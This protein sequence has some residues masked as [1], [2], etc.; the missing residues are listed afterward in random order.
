MNNFLNKKR[1]TVAQRLMAL[2]LIVAL[3]LSTFAPV[4]A[5][6]GNFGNASAFEQMISGMY[7]GAQG[8][9]T[10]S[11]GDFAID[12]AITVAVEVADMWYYTH[13]YS[14]YGKSLISF[15]I[16][17]TRID[18]SR[19][20][21]FRM[22]ASV[23]ASTVAGAVSGRGISVG[24]IIER[25]VTE[26]A[27]LVIQETI[28]DLLVRKFGMSPTM[29]GLISSLASKFISDN[30]MQY[31]RLMPERE[32]ELPAPAASSEPKKKRVSKEASGKGEEVGS[33]ETAESGER[34]S[35][36]SSSE[37]FYSS[38]TGQRV[39]GQKLRGK[40]LSEV[41]DGK[42]DPK[43]KQLQ[44]SRAFVGKL[45]A[46]VS[47]LVHGGKER[48]V[49]VTA[50]E[51]AGGIR[52]S[53]QIIANDVKYREKLINEQKS[54]KR[55]AKNYER[56]MGEIN[57]R[58]EQQSNFNGILRE[59]YKKVSANSEVRDGAP[60][61]VTVN[62]VIAGLVESVKPRR[63]PVATGLRNA[64]NRTFVAGMG[65]VSPE[66]AAAAKKELGLNE[67]KPAVKF[68]YT[69]SSN[70]STGA[71]RKSQGASGTPGTT[72]QRSFSSGVGRG[73][74]PPLPES[75]DGEF[76]GGGSGVLPDKYGGESA[77]REE[78]ES[79][80][81]RGVTLSNGAN[82]TMRADGSYRDQNGN[83]Y[84]RKA[85][86]GYTKVGSGEFFA[87]KVDNAMIPVPPAP[88]AAAP[89]TQPLK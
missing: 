37:V 29:A 50:N 15:D 31:T 70:N 43:G 88:Q 77:R 12:I 42:I 10:Q 89:I 75:Y 80:Y 32:E 34:E 44:Y 86:D 7:S 11:W 60:A 6:S 67:Q 4:Y 79:S 41:I 62:S 20:Q 16:G 8:S 24:T 68:N 30:F 47:N 28:R 22:V 27:Q 17:G 39:I 85:Q 33:E 48:E 84:L 74:Q 57:A 38:T 87:T 35:G 82:L 69:N 25:V 54:G 9:S 14:E 78:P 49:E 76:D 36:S 2:V 45:K 5:R 52:T 21:M 83:A 66:T 40:T 58:I 1:K 73:Q 65:V 3:V 59:L 23:A 56:L 26:F 19:G 55:S 71:Q 51:L 81:P 18:I 64:V 53:D 46:G 13:Y 72:L 61:L 63:D